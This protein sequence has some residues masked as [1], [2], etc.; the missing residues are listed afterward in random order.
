M[1]GFGEFGRKKIAPFPLRMTPDQ[2]HQ[3]LIGL[4]RAL[5]VFHETP[6][7]EITQDDL[8]LK[9]QIATVRS[10]VLRAESGHPFPLRSPHQATPP[11]DGDPELTPPP[12][13]FRRTDSA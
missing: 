10:Q 3:V 6:P 5:F 2:Y 8:Q 7:T 4:D 9:M 13:S 1:D 11:S 12:F